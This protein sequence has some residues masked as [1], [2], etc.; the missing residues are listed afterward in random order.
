MNNKE[1]IK[2]D[3][4]I[5]DIQ[6]AIRKCVDLDIPLTFINF[7]KSDAN[8]TFLGKNKVNL[9]LDYEQILNQINNYIANHMADMIDKEK[10]ELANYY[11]KLLNEKNEKT[12]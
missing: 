8:Y 4:F 7:K 10:L 3:Y 5:A 1:P 12:T 9:L 6:E 2:D 11:D